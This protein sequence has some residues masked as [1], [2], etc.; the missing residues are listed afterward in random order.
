MNFWLVLGFCGQALFAA[1]FLIQWICSEKRKES[2][3]PVIFWYL[4][5]GGGLILLSYAIH[6]KDPVFI[7]GQAT[8]L[9]IYL[10]NLVL[11]ARRTSMGRQQACNITAP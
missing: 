5:I 1:R 8:G 2:H 10:R 3:V 6:R 11:I 4:S 9:V 7:V